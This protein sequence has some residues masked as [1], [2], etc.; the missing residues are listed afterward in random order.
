[1][2]GVKDVR[3]VEAALQ[4]FDKVGDGG[5][6][7]GRGAKRKISPAARNKA[8]KVAKKVRLG[9]A[10]E[11]QV[12]AGIDA[13]PRTVQRELTRAGATWVRAAAKKPPLTP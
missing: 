1:M 6:A 3:T 2:F 12:L 7:P 11:L 9:G 4:K 13:S 5:V 8:V 10:K